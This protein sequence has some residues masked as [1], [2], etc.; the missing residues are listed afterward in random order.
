M[1]SAL[2]GNG[3]PPSSPRPLVL[4]KRRAVCSDVEYEILPA[5]F[6]PAEAMKRIAPL[7]HD[8]DGK[9]RP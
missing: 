9:S 4:L 5:V 8:N 7:L 3:L 2:P 1:L 6:D